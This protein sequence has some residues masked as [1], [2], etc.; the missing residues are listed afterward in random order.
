MKSRSLGFFII[1]F[2]GLFSVSNAGAYTVIGCVSDHT[3][4]L[5]YSDSGVQ[6][7]QNSSWNAYETTPVEPDGFEGS[8]NYCSPHYIKPC[9]IRTT[10]KCTQCTGPYYDNK[11]KKWYEQ[12]GKEYGYYQC[13]IDDYAGLLVVLVGGI[14]FFALRKAF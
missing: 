1:F 6:S 14:G 5:Y 4:Y 8:G 2:L 7:L 10:S 12:K 11:G 3:G 9:V 13:P